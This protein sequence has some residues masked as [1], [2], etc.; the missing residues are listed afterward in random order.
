M[1]ASWLAYGA[2]A[3]IRLLVSGSAILE[4]R[5][6][7]SNPLNAWKRLV[8]GIHLTK[9]GL[10]PY[11]G[12]VYHE[13][14]L[15]VHLFCWLEDLVLAHSH[16]VFVAGDLVTCHLLS[17]LG[18]SLALGLQASQRDQQD[19]VHPEA[20]SLIVPHNFHITLPKV[21]TVV[22]LFNPFI[23]CNC[24]ARTS[25]VWSNLL[26]TGSLLGMINNNRLLATAALSLAA[27]QS[28]YPLMLL[29]PLSLQLARHEG[30]GLDR[31]GVV[32]VVKTVSLFCL[33]LA[34][35]LVLSHQLTGSWQ[36]IHSTY[37]FILSVPELTPN[38]GIFWYFFTEMFEHFRVF[39]LATFQLNLLMYCLPLSIRFSGEPVLV[40]V[41]LVG[42]TAVFKSYPGL[43]DV[44]YFLSLLPIFSRLL[45]FL[46]Q[47][48]VTGGMIVATTA[49]APIA[50]QLWIYNN[51]ANANYYFAINLVFSTAQ[52]F[53]VTDLLFAQV[54]LDF[55]LKHGSS[56]V[57]KEVD[58]KKFVLQLK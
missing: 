47:T 34:V 28:L 50:W 13:S 52:I 42:L 27:Y 57:D 51:S 9:L 11:E 49:L 31:R 41:V 18:R 45:P 29:F 32:S 25:T 35:L 21:L 19:T 56:V 16:L 37:G 44:G 14:P 33:W 15:L 20:S 24:A 22:Y 46:K 8:E 6:E 10:S 55:Y 54:R 1:G 43:G 58:G 5:P 4:D 26:L 3:V 40:W 36:F 23:I 38:M 2:G 48:F 53:L 7:I 39:F 12:V 30:G 17:R